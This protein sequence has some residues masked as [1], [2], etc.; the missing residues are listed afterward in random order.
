MQFVFTM[1]LGGAQLNTCNVS[2]SG[3]PEAYGSAPCEP[4][5]LPLHDIVNCNMALCTTLQSTMSC[6][7]TCF[8]MTLHLVDLIRMDDGAHI[9]CV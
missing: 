2:V 3:Y 5:E 1:A 4:C 8:W 6:R 9:I 7:T